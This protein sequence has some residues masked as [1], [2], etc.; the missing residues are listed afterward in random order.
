MKEGK[1]ERGTDSER[2]RE[3]V[4]RK[5]I[6]QIGAKEGQEMC[7]RKGKRGRSREIRAESTGRRD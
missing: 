1:T 5:N 4:S 6:K 3:R 7:G 2:E